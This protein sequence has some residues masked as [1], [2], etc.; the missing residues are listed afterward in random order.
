MV[1]PLKRYVTINVTV[2]WCNCHLLLDNRFEVS[3]YSAKPYWGIKEMNDLQTCFWLS[4]CHI[5]PGLSY[6]DE[7]QARGGVSLCLLSF[8]LIKKSDTP[9]E[10]ESAWLITA[11]MLYPQKNW[12]LRSLWQSSCGI[13]W[14]GLSVTL[15]KSCSPPWGLPTLKSA[16]WFQTPKLPI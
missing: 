11:P 14:C 4:K 2:K 8:P 10:R 3:L 15:C 9:W 7:W 12:A 16:I 5:H 13:L 1:E 6:L